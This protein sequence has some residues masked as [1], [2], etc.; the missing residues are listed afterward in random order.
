MLTQEQVFNFLQH[1]HTEEPER[2]Y[3]AA[4]ENLL[5]KYIA[6]R[7]PKAVD[8]AL[9]IF[10]PH[11]CGKMSSDPILQ[12]LFLSSSYV[13]LIARMFIDNGL[14]STFAFGVSDLFLQQLNTR[15][16]ES[17][18]YEWAKQVITF[19]LAIQVNSGFR[20]LPPLQF[21]SDHINKAIE[22][23]LT[24]IAEPLSTQ[25]IADALHISQSYLSARFHKEVGLTIS[26]YIHFHKIEVA[27]DMLIR[28]KR[29]SAEISQEL[30]FSSQSHFISVF[31]R[32]VGMTPNDYIKSQRS[33]YAPNANSESIC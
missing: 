23:I 20:N 5:V 9:F 11:R 3:S 29:P 25:K 13:T 17:D 33:R 12:L 31:R 30:S 15:M 27:K 32:F 10:N 26:S 24:H 8:Q 2:D 22:Y 16:T 28:Q 4:D 19:Y 6:A 21:Y 7:D 14:S 1:I 18:F